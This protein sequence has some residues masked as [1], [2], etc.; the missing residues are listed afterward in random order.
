MELPMSRWGSL[1]P[2]WEVGEA[3]EENQRGTFSYVCAHLTAAS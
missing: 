2:V 1:G 3:E